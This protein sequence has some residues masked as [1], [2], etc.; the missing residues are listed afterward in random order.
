MNELGTALS[1]GLIDGITLSAALGIVIL[2]S[3]YLNARLWLHD[4]PQAM[5]ERVPPLTPRERQA[6]MALSLVF[7]GILVGGLALGVSGLESASGGSAT[8]IAVFVYSL[9]VLNLFN[10]FDASVLDYAILARMK[11]KFAVLPGT[12]DLLYLFDDPRMHVTNYLKGVV[13]SLVASLIV[14]VV[15]VL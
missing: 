9:L 10:L 5:R 11:P 2:I 13:F 12:E 14:A 1:R 15:A 4:Y 7:F 6:R 3:L 8:F